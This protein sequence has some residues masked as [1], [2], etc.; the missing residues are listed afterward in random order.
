MNSFRQAFAW[1]CYSNKG[2]GAEA[3]LAG[4]ANI[5]YKGVDLIEEALWPVARNHGLAIAAIGGHTT[6]SEGLNRADQAARIEKELRENIAKAHEWK[7]PV[8]ICFSGNRHGA[9]DEEGIDECAK[10]L[11][12]IAPEAASAGV[13]LAME[14]LNS[15]VDHQ[16]YQ[17]DH[18]AWGVEL[19]RRVNSPAVKL[20][21]DIYHM[22]IMEGDIIRTIRADHD[23]FA[24]Y[25]TA[26]N[27][28]RGPNDETQEIYYPPIYRAIA[29]TGYT[30]YVAHEFS[31]S[32][33]PLE[34]LKKA[35]DDTLAA[36]A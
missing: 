7:I 20:L 26:G 23:Y 2:V 34:G 4:A 8:L 18:T 14:L 17:C 5:G 6:L 30:G 24:H 28:G 33:D 11:S 12:K 29:K 19:C 36:L 27:P 25:H 9:T 16:G 32:G 13:V 15:K 21:Y 1:W 22:Q 3:L 31:P 10:Q 35:Y